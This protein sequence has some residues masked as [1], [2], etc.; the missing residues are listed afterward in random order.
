M[1]IIPPAMMHQYH[2]CSLIKHEITQYIKLEGDK[3]LKPKH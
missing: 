3:L 2:L 1:N